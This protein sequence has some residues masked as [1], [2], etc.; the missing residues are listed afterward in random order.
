MQ[1]NSNVTFNEYNSVIVSPLLI[2]LHKKI[3]QDVEWR[4]WISATEKRKVDDK[5]KN[6]LTSYFGS[7]GDVVTVA[8]SK[9]HTHHD[10]VSMPRC[11]TEERKQMKADRQYMDKHRINVAISNNLR[12]VRNVPLLEK[13]LLTLYK[14]VRFLCYLR[15]KDGLLS[16]VYIP[17][18]TSHIS[19]AFHVYLW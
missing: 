6:E 15:T 4:R 14:R 11:S 8:D 5:D 2:N 3:V 7:S 9:E 19:M 1:F 16:F 12:L 13:S 18:N 10:V 17:T